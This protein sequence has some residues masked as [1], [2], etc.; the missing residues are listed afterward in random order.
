VDASPVSE[1]R[2][3]SVGAGGV[4]EEGKGGLRRGRRRLRAPVGKLTTRNNKTRRASAGD[5][6]LLQDF[7]A[8]W[9]GR[10][11]EQLAA[12]NKF[13]IEELLPRVSARRAPAAPTPSTSTKR[14][15]AN[16][17][18]ATP[19]PRPKPARRPDKRRR[20]TYAYHE[21]GHAVVSH[22]LGCKALS[23]TVI[24]AGASAG[25][26]VHRNPLRRVQLD[27]YRSDRVRLRA[28]RAIMISLAGP[29]AQRRYRPRSWRRWHGRFDFRRAAELANR[30]CGSTEQVSAFLAWLEVK[31]RDLV[32]SYWPEIERVADSL[33]ERQRLDGAEIMAAI[34][35]KT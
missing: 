15:T 33:F 2:Q 20:K 4:G 21:A 22:F 6:G 13:V 28:E 7:D 35:R 1:T 32:E 25:A 17:S 9:N 14:G 24:P 29:L 8:W 19:A 10:P 5:K 27:L 23:A 12:W 18:H 16:P 3:R 34:N 26:A 30:V 11:P 31:T